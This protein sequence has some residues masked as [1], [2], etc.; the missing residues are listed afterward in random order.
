M[1]P[2]AKSTKP[3]VKPITVVHNFGGRRCVGEPPSVATWGTWDCD[4]SGDG[5]PPTQRHAYGADFPWH[6]D[7]E[8]KAYVIEGSATLTADEP[9]KHGPPITIG[10][11]DMVTFPKGWR[12]RWHV[13][14]FLKKRY[15]FFDAK[16]LR[17][18]EDEDEDEDED[19]ERSSPKR[20]RDDAEAAEAGADGDD[21]DDAESGEDDEEPPS[22][23][24]RR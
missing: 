23:T 9:D 19:T 2:K 14:A 16:G 13:E 8:E 11:R 5:R 21:D 20:S 3:R 17:V 10:P 4:P 18:D 1:A 22:K 15:A 24:S 6:F 7:L 12:G